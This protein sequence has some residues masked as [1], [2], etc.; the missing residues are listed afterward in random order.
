M[1]LN[2][3]DVFSGV[4]FSPDGDLL[5]IPSDGDESLNLT[6]SSTSIS[7]GTVH[8][9]FAQFAVLGGGTGD[10]DAAA[11][12]AAAAGVSA[13]ATAGAGEAAGEGAGPLPS[14]RR[15]SHQLQDLLNLPGAEQGSMMDT[16]DSAAA[17]AAAAEQARAAHQL[18]ASKAQQAAQAAAAHAQAQTS[19]PFGAGAVA[20]K[21][22]PIP[23]AGAVGGV[24]LQ[25]PTPPP[26]AATVAAGA[27]AASLP[28]RGGGISAATTGGGVSVAWGRG[29][30]SG[31][32][33]TAAA[34]RR[35]RHKVSSK[36]LTEEQRIER[37]SRNREHAKRS[38]VRKKFLLDSLQRSVDAIQAENESLKGAVV[39]SL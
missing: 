30:Q 4:F 18:A 19:T 31:A 3:D 35:Q 5:D 22:H 20:E 16:D 8:P 7:E 32:G 9:P 38:R 24:P 13:E 23:A 15:S 33:A 11:A 28:P 21:A 34:P 37:R 1:N 39:G 12:A 17:A 6:L 25:T 29:P 26:T 2:L 10:G 14:V 27:G 36:D